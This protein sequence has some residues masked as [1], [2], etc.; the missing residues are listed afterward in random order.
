M[1]V[2]LQ[3]LREK[4]L[5]WVKSNRENGFDEGI[6]RLLTE[7]YPDNAHFI[8]ELLQNAED[9]QA[10]SVHF[11]LTESDVR[12]SHNGKRLFNF[13]DV[14]SITSIGN[15][16]KRDD[17][18]SIGKFGVGFKAVF[19][20]TNTPEIH[21]G[22]FHFRIC[23]LVV[24]ETEGVENVPVDQWQTR[25]LF[26]FD[27]PNKPPETA[28]EEI[29]KGLL[30]L[31]D[32]TL[33][34]L[35]HIRKI[36]YEL[37]DGSVG[38]LQRI[39]HKD[40]RIEIRASHANNE[41]K[42]S[43][44]LHCR[45]DVQ[46]NDEKSNIKSCSVAVAYQLQKED[47]K[48]NKNA[49]WK[50]VPVDGEVSIYFPAEKE[51]S[52]LR[53]HIHAPF[54]STV[55]RDSVRDCPANEQ[56]RDY[57][58][59]LIVESL[60]TIK[61]QG[62]LNMGF[63][64]ILPNTRDNLTGFYKPLFLAILNA[65][66]QQSLTPTKTGKHAKAKTLYR[67][68]VKI[69]DIIN[70][71]YLKTLTNDNNALWAANP[72]QRNQSADNF[73]DSLEIKKWDFEQLSGIFQEGRP[74]EVESWLLKMND[75]WLLSFYELLYEALKT[76]EAT[77]NKLPTW[78]RKSWPGKSFPLVR[79]ES[80]NNIK[81]VKSEQAYFRLED[82]RI[83]P[84]PG[85]E[86]VKLSVYKN[87]KH[88]NE[89]AE[90]FLKKLG[91]RPF[92]EKAAI[93]WRLSKYQSPSLEASADHYNDIKQFVEYWKKNN[94]KTIFQQ[95]RFLLDATKNWK[96]CLELCLDVPFIETGLA[97]LVEVHGKSA[98]WQGYKE[99]LNENEIQDFL[100][101]AK[102]V[103][104]MHK[105]EVIKLT[106][107]AARKNPNTPNR[108][109]NWTST[110]KCDD[111][112][113]VDLEKY[114]SIKKLSA[115][116][117]IWNAILAAQNVAC[118]ASFK[119][120][121]QYSVVNIDSQ[122]IYF[123]KSHAWI[124]DSKDEFC[125]PRAMTHETLREDFPFDDR[126][127]LLTKLDFGKNAK[128]AKQLEDWRKNHQDKNEQER[129][130]TIQNYAHDIGLNSIDELTE[131][132][133]LIQQL[134]GFDEVRLLA[135]TKSNSSFDLPDRNS[136]NSERRAVNV[137][138]KANSLPIKAQSIRPRTVTDSYGF[139]QQDAR[140]Y[141]VAQYK[142]EDILICQIC[143]REQPVKVNE[144]YIFIAADCIPELDKFYEPNKLCLC[145][146]HWKMY[147]ESN[148]TAE[149]IIKNISGLDAKVG[150]Q[151]RKLI[152]D[153]GGN[154]VSLYFTQN[155]LADLQAVIKCV[156]HSQQDDL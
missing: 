131:A 98:L 117:L 24:P 70:D 115:S 82:D 139:S 76:Y 104:I 19:A 3:A 4:R 112:S 80:K 72:P 148:L 114:L 121:Q 11:K 91:V 8:Y 150:K 155:H 113:I 16:T 85:I 60:S 57:L 154:Q 36:E 95:K 32:N 44:W 35:S 71:K 123:L 101:F 23:D 97:E 153:L 142:D 14:E 89:D 47:A 111:Y 64:A 116:R 119:P 83:N 49:D 9:P 94:D 34:F 26:P 74:D 73:L 48:Q 87:G 118:N 122:L 42:R 31:G 69:S 67:G 51:S 103:G 77:Q 40:G 25:F 106:D 156:K 100:D 54:A 93:E 17:E 141:L 2:E 56:L 102:N 135:Q 152:L 86:I 30:A 132:A 147:K 108:S 146:N 1:S 79:V 6:N 53:F 37:T 18:T 33:L 134:G 45:K 96:K 61:K 88:I 58:G 65:F 133:R 29:E 50:I 126:N 129:R 125:T 99:N 110:G 145:P 109:A 5:N 151:E 13:K 39:N 92:D 143:Q 28:I 59:D 120:N 10:T 105:L 68:P 149:Y 138:N 90:S 127:G 46:V 140:Q 20:Y 41:P 43:Y 63:L 52:K 21:S 55:A 128:D 22:S 78:Q 15:S 75:A 38:S 144:E 12:F 62:M 107:D 27:N 84:P 81:H 137:E 124:I 7:L 136:N 66:N 130:Q